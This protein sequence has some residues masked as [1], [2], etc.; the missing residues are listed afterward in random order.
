MELTT[1]FVI[2]KERIFRYRRGKV[3][4]Y[5]ILPAILWLTIFTYVPLVMAVDRVFRDYNTR[6]F[7]GWE[8]FDYVLKTPAFVNSFRNVIAFTLIITT[9]MFLCSFFFALLIKNI[10]FPKLMGTIKALIYLPNLLSGVIVTII[11]N[12]L[13]NEGYG[14]F[15]A[16]RVANGQWPIKFTTDGIWPYISIIIPSLWM[17]LGYNTLVMLA[18]LLNIPK[19]YYEA[20]KIDGANAAVA[21]WAITV[22]N[23][24][25]S[26]ILILTS[27]ITGNLQ[28]LEIP[29]WITGGGPLNRTMTPALYLFNSFR[30]AGRSPNVA[31]AGALLIML[32][33]ALLNIVSF[34]LLHSK[35]SEDV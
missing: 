22:P 18:G 2:K 5:F 12:M 31:I 7:V 17:G 20:A 33:I 14:L 1:E 21:L 10:E 19:E 27:Q 23:M 13:I 9:L 8:H 30:D 15:A 16:M 25:N 4:Y 34:S 3:G 24:R 11:F 32:L 35:K 29:M 26:F 6:E 28:M